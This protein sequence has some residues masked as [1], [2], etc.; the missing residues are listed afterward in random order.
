MTEQYIDERLPDATRDLALESRAR[1]ARMLD[2]LVQRACRLIDGDC[3]TVVM[4]DRR[5]PR[6]AICVEAHNGPPVGERYPADVGVN[7]EVFSTHGPVLTA[8]DVWSIAAVPVRWGGEV[9][10]VLSVATADPQLRFGREDVA[11]LCELAEFAAVLLE[12]ME[13]HERLAAVLERGVRALARAAELHDHQLASSTEQVVGLAL[14]VGEQV[15]VE[16]RGLIELE[17]AARLHD[18]GKIGV[19][20]EVL[21]KPGTLS[22]AEWAIVQR[23]PVW[24]AGMLLAIP[25]LEAVAAIVEAVHERWDGTGYPQGLRS[26]EIPLASRI[27]LA[28][29]A[30]QAM[31][32][33][34][35]YRRAVE[36][37]VALAELF[38]NAGTQFDPAVV[39]ALSERLV[40]RGVTAADQLRIE[41]E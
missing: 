20:G 36:P 25:G 14:E 38:A 35:P 17:F 13:M 34:R 19:P 24:A 26:S 6:V 12:N 4:R 23:H 16:G 39:R 32:S 18:L 1:A 27:I 31:V 29:E 9:R 11:A 8:V 15:G 41:L 7:G 37:P 5:D 10:A 2:R 33:E 21:S 40:I 3:A 30:Y 28:C 22:D